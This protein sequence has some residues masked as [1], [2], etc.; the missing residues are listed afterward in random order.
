MFWNR[1]PNGR[2]DVSPDPGAVYAE[3]E[4]SAIIQSK[5][6]N[7]FLAKQNVAK[8]RGI[9][10]APGFQPSI[11]AAK[12]GVHRAD[13]RPQGQKVHEDVVEHNHV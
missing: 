3:G 11:S 10:H 6:R 7:Q 9:M 1:L 13:Q 12:F 8:Q 5:Q 4:M 2:N